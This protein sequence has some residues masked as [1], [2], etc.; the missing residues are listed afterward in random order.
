MMQGQQ[1]TP[2]WSS[3]YI[4]II[5][6]VGAAVGMG[7]IWRFP[8]LAGESGGGAFVLIYIFFVI[9]LGPPSCYGRISTRASREEKPGRNHEKIGSA[10]A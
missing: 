5:A 9:V 4:F 10:R 2:Q 7:N 6:A 3:E 8:Y 1:K